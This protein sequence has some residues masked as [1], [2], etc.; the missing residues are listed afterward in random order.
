MDRIMSIMTKLEIPII[1]LAFTTSFDEFETWMRENEIGG[2]SVAMELRSFGEE[3]DTEEIILASFRVDLKW[4]YS[5]RS[6][7]HTFVSVWK[8]ERRSM[9]SHCFQIDAESMNLIDVN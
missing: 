5:N 7:W 8:R 3:G 1:L 6:R 2:R 9:R 4:D